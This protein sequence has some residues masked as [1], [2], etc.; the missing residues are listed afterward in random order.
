[1]ILDSHFFM[2]ECYLLKNKYPA[3]A[4][5]IMG[6]TWDDDNLSSKKKKYRINS[7]SKEDQDKFCMILLK[8]YSVCSSF[9]SL[10]INGEIEKA[11]RQCGCLLYT[12]P[13]PRD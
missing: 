1:M 2:M 9:I 5:Q 8:Y 13:S 12:S 11:T 10:I 6:Y 7:F 4:Y 3:G